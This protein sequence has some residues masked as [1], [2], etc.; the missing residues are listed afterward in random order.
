MGRLQNRR[1]RFVVDGRPVAPGLHAVGDASVCT[2]PLY[3]RGC[4]L[5]VVHAALLADVM[6]DHPDDVVAQALAFDAATRREL[7]PWY[8][9]AVAQDAQARRTD[10]TARPERGGLLRAVR[11][12]PDLFRAFLRVFNLLDRPEAVL[13][14]PDLGARIQAAL[15]DE[16]PAT[17]PPLGPSRAVLLEALAG[18]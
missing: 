11:R 6:A 9:A 16:E 7:M 12:D 17:G 2:N 18:L 13:A 15:A 3:G 8:R 4:T 5:A 1:R 14:R 10:G